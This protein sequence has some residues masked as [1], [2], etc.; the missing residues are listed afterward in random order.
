MVIDWS[1]AFTDSQWD[2]LISEALHVC[3]LEETSSRVAAESALMG[4]CYRYGKHLSR[5]NIHQL[6]N[7]INQRID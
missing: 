3:L 5:V 1:I 4:A 7:E 6:S 2:E